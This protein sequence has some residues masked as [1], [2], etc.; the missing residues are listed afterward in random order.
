M[1]FK[2]ISLDIF[3]TLVDVTS[4]K[5]K[6]W[7]IFLNGNYSSELAKRGWDL[8]TQKILD[9]FSIE[10]IEKAEFETVKSVFS[11]CYLEVF[12]KINIDFNHQ[13]AA[14][15]LAYNHNYAMPYRDTEKFMNFIGDKY[16]YIIS[17]DAD[18]DMVCGIKYLN[19]SDKI[20]TSEDLKC[21]KMSKD[22]GFFETVLK[23]YKLNPNT[24]LHIGDSAADII[25][26]K[27]IGIK[28]CW[29]NRNNST[30]Q[31]DIAPD[32]IFTGLENVLDIL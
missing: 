31:Y 11:K 8:A 9:Y 26:P 12:Q 32:Y 19:K 1:Q 7:R 10:I 14:H 3:Q 27:K 29:I 18:N 5:E 28:T 21:Y 20:F 25:N 4:I 15:I 2:L 17:S 13:K 6:I 30:W 16:T 23:H 24:I 22:N